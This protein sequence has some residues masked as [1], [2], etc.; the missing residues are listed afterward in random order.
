MKTQFLEYVRNDYIPNVLQF[1]FI[2]VHLDM[3]NYK[4]KQGPT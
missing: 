2:N 4:Q 1:K 3:I